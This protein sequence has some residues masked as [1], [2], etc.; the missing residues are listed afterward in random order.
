MQITHS[1]AFMGKKCDILRFISEVENRADEPS[2]RVLKESISEILDETEH[3]SPCDESCLTPNF[4]LLCDDAVVQLIVTDLPDIWSYDAEVFLGIAPELNLAYFESNDYSSFY[5]VSPSG[6]INFKSDNDFDNKMLGKQLFKINRMLGITLDKIDA[7][8]FFDNTFV[9]VGGF[10]HDTTKE[11]TAIR[12]II[13]ENGGKVTDNISTKTDFL[14]IGG[15]RSQENGWKEYQS[16]I[17]YRAQGQNIRIISEDDLLDPLK[18]PKKNEGEASTCVSPQTRKPQTSPKQSLE[19]ATIDGSTWTIKT[20]DDN[21]C[22][23]IK[24]EGDE[25]KLCVPGTLNGF[26]VV[27]VSIGRYDGNA[28][29]F[30]NCERIILPSEV[31]RLEKYVFYYCGMEEITL[32]NT[33]T[34][35]GDCA[36]SYCCN[37]VYIELPS[38]VTSIGKFAFADCS[39]LKS[40]VIPGGV[41]KLLPATFARCKNLSDV[42]LLP[43]VVSIDNAFINC[44]M[45]EN[46]TI[47][48][49]V[50]KINEKAFDKVHPNLT[51]H[52]PAGSFA[53]KFAGENEIKF[54]AI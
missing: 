29:S 30:K 39:N 38:G 27:S 37:L 26:S 10:I 18:T 5:L 47:P 17:H 4:H 2:F 6:Q 45:L 9:L 43:G 35:I 42:T 21:T 25:K 54:A 33:L 52:A 46:I 28:S 13:S 32:S 50:K 19:T 11:K 7:I 1:M 36:F 16:A 3:I 41:S 40:I 15:N 53:E 24:Y 14:V 31:T 34:Y 22:S 51:I 23:I 48:E 12:Q 20:I 49:S 8:P 44:E